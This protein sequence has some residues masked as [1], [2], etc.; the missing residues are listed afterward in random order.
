MGT[1]A[2]A[3]C[4]LAPPL[5][6]THGAHHVP[7]ATIDG[8]ACTSDGAAVH[9]HAATIQPAPG[10]PACAAGPTWAGVPA[11]AASARP[12]ALAVP[13]WLPVATGV[14]TDLRP[15]RCSRAPPAFATV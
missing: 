3:L 8:Q 10:C 5:V 2:L 14:G 15:A 12:P 4:L 13:A 11:Q 9:L 7:I 1:L 6:H